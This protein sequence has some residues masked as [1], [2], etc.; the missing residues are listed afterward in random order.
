[1]DMICVDIGNSNISLAVFAK[2]K[3]DRTERVPV[4]QAQAQKLA[5]ILT[6]FREICGP[7]PLGAK[8]VPITV[9]SVNPDALELVERVVTDTFKQNVLL[10]GRDFP[11]EMK[12]AVENPEAVGKDR[13]ITAFAAFEVIGRA[14]VIADFGTA[15]TID[16]VND[17]GIFLGGVIFP[18]LSL[19]A[20]SLNAYTA[21]LPNVK[22]RIPE[23]TF[24]TNTIMAIQ[25]GIYYSAIGA[26]REIVERYAEELG[27]WPQ[28][29]VTGGFANMIAQKCD[30]IDSLVPDLCLNGL[31]LAYRRFHESQ[32]AEEQP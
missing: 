20:R 14:A 18:G 13:L 15:T 6:A 32:L 27:C 11:L 3:L 4:D 31:Y 26:L 5:D 2:G 9:S 24:G 25:N 7:Q 23:S 19:A 17:N 29:V 21:A 22:P 1:M 12:T 16:C 8:T 10:I 28:V 30:F